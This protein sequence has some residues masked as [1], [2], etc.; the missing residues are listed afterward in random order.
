MSTPSANRRSSDASRLERTLM[1]RSDQGRDEAPRPARSDEASGALSLTGATDG[2]GRIGRCRWAFASTV[3]L[4]LVGFLAIVLTQGVQAQ[5]GKSV[6][7]DRFDVTLTLRNDGSYH[8]T[9]RQE[10]NFQGGPF[11]GG[12]ADIPLGR[13]DAI[14]GLV[15]REE[16]ASGIRDYEF[17]PW[18]DFEEAPGTY[19]ATTT[20]SQITVRYGF[21]PTTNQ[22]R[23]FLL[24]YDVSGALR[25]Y[26]DNDPPN[27]QIWWTAIS[28]EVTEVAP[29]RTASMT[30]VLP[31]PIGDL[32]QV[33][34][35]GPG[36]DTAQSHTTDGKTWTWQ[37]TDLTNGEDFE[38]RLQFPP[39]VNAAPPN[40]Q[41][42]DDE[43]RRSEEEKDERS[44]VLN[45]IFLGIGLLALAGGGAGLYGLWYS[46][47]RDPHTGVVADFIPT[48]PDDLPPGAAGTLLDER[49]DERDVTATLVDLANRGVLK[50]DETQSPSILGFGGSR[51]FL[52]T[53]LQATPKVTPF[54]AELLRSLFGSSL[55]EGQTAKLSEVKSRFTSATPRIK[56]LLY[57]ELV[58]RGY[59]PRS[60]EKTRSSWRSGGVALL[61]AVILLGC[62]GAG[63]VADVAPFA[64]F[65][66]G[67]L[68]VLGLAIVYLS[69]VMPRKTQAGAE[70]A[71]KWR[72][73]RRYLDDIEKYEQVAESR[74]IFDTYLPYAIAFGLE[75]S[76]VAKFAGVGAATPGWY[77]P[78]V[79]G[80]PFT[81]DP[82]PGQGPYG[83]RRGGTVIFGPGGGWSGGGSGGGQGDGGGF[84]LPDLQDTSDSAGRSLQRS[85]DSLLDMFNTA[86]KV[87]GGFGGGGSSGGSSGGGGRGFN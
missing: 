73:F 4:I 51:D 61:V 11:R 48:P 52:L 63:I 86:A 28:S 69:S 49:A 24:E 26:L 10:I 38:V 85:S 37:A 70:A 25:V 30:I 68:V 7:W 14:R 8:V 87:F 15:V 18:S 62:F 41:Q 32:S 40:W 81:S 83:R 39:I 55:K 21:E 46:R 3:V 33:M 54:E 53:A 78:V 1:D 29:V 44:A 57:E 75:N 16:T 43:Q 59:F 71:A 9:E 23:T 22:K 13:I 72:A 12:F 42:R 58:K 60:P 20:S 66:V 77:G 82:F 64:W 31:A 5:G 34:L 2:A 47:G 19:T 36:D 17:V 74:Q 45:V 35:S 67:V 80:G 27:Q 84:D 76:W 6:V 65:L 79:V 56:E 50:M